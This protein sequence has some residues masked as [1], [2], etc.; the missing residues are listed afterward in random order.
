MGELT[1]K[2]R[3][4]ECN[5]A[6]QN[7]LLIYYM[8]TIPKTDRI[9]PCHEPDKATYVLPNYCHASKSLAGKVGSFLS[10]HFVSKLFVLSTIALKQMHTQRTFICLLQCMLSIDVKVFCLHLTALKVVIAC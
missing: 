3:L 4:F 2:V 5:L 9:T 1:A 10:L 6:H 7:A 8:T